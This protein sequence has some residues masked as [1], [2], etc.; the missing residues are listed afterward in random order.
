M[1][2]QDKFFV[3]L[4]NKAAGQVDE[5]R[6]EALLYGPLPAAT[7]T[8]IFAFA[9]WFKTYMKWLPEVPRCGRCDGTPMEMTVYGFQS[10]HQFAPDPSHWTG[11][12][13]MSLSRT[14]T[15]RKIERYVCPRC[16]A[17]RIVSRESN[18]IMIVQTREGRCGEHAILFTA[19]CNA[20]GMQAR[21]VVFKDDDHV[22]TEVFTDGRWLPVDP[23]VENAD[24]IELDRDLFKRWGWKLTNVVAYEPYQDPVDVSETYRI[25]HP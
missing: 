17:L 18:P 22:I 8:G 11:F 1:D 12:R 20:L 21:L 10:S 14:I 9:R 23:S 2:N 7:S 25:P 13:Q 3:A 4:M 24:R 15:C 6:A 19:F 16:H 5:L